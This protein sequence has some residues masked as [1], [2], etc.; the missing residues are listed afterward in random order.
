MPRSPLGP[1]LRSVWWQV[2]ALEEAGVGRPSTYASTLRTLV[3]RAYV[4]KEGRRLVPEM[5]GLLVAAFL[6]HYFP[7]YV[8]TAFTAQLEAQLDDITAGT[9]PY[10]AVLTA[11][12]TDLQAAIDDTAAISKQQVSVGTGKRGTGCKVVVP[13]RRCV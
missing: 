12:H 13:R 6:Q 2:K 8:D 11:F 3:D 4:R 9:R 1:T 5:R 7:R 10:K